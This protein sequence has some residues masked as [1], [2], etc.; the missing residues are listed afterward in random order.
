MND[1]AVNSAR[2]DAPTTVA[3]TRYGWSLTIVV[4]LGEVVNQRLTDQ[5]VTTGDLEKRVIDWVGRV[6]HD[7]EHAT[8]TFT[9]VIQ[10]VS[11]RDVDQLVS[12]VLYSLGAAP[13]RVIVLSA[14]R[15]SRV[16]M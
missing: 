14:V 16:V 5:V 15:G 4:S 8:I 11:F 10:A 2:G 9:G 13:D 3:A 12:D 7:P 6:T 1:G